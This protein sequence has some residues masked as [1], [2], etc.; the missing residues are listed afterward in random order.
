VLFG[1]SSLAAR[2]GG[3]LPHSLNGAPV[4]LPATGLVRD[5]LRRW[6]AE[7]SITVRVTGE[8]DDAAMLRTFGIRGHVPCWYRGW[9]V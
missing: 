3:D 7:R 5:G 2:F 9:T 1:T 6:F 8:F 4:L